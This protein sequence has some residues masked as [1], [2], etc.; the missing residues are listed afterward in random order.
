MKDF[1]ISYTK[2]DEDWAVWIAWQLEEAGHT[3]V[4]QK[5]DFHAGQ[6]FVLAMQAASSNAK[7][8]IAVL[9]PDYLRSDFAKSEWS[10]AFASDPTG[11]KG[12]LIPI[13]VRPVDVKD[14]LGPIIHID[15]TG[16]SEKEA[17]ELL[18]E[19]KASEDGRRGKPEV[20]PIFPS[21]SS[22]NGNRSTRSPDKENP[23]EATCVQEETPEFKAGLVDKDEQATH[24]LDYLGK[25]YFVKEE[26]PKNPLAYLLY[27]AAT[28]WPDALLNILYVE[29][30][31]NLKHLSSR[32]HENVSPIPKRL[33]RRMLR[34]NIN[35]DD[36]FY[37][38]LGNELT[39]GL[40]RT[41]I[42]TRLSKAEVPLIFYRV[43]TAA[44][45]NDPDL[46]QGMLKAWQQLELSINSPRHILILYYEYVEVPKSSW[47]FFGKS[48]KTLIHH[49]NA[50]L[51]Q[52]M[53]QKIFLPKLKSPNKKL[54][55]DWINIH[56]NQKIED[57][58]KYVEDRIS[59]ELKNRKKKRQK[60]ANRII[61]TD[62]DYEIH[63]HDLRDILIDALKQYG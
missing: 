20:K 16:S 23:T 27:G 24:I 37:E 33:T 2:T 12:K 25:K 32:V 5:W 10:A 46:V 6:N 26:T 55:H 31:N 38:L 14:I 54:V 3:T 48:E 57:A 35:P 50:S 39:C 41:D 49:L 63:H 30:K 45:S 28:Q 11:K 58:K 29:L 52:E 61:I 9:S 7:H 56:F 17:T 21:E 22:L 4:I 15:L 42:E 19:I 1:F 40:N 8:T 13:K 44:E 47:S 43:L 34:R 62:K 51:P 53:C 36:Y 18:Q 59:D 60:E